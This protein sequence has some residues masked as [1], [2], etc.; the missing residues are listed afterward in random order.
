[1]GR[2]P[3]KRTL[4]DNLKVGC[5]SEFDGRTKFVRQMRERYG[6]LCEELGGYDNLKPSQRDL[7]EKYIWCL[8]MTRKFEALMIDCDD[9]AKHEKIH[10]RWVNATNVLQGVCKRLGLAQPI[11]VNSSANLGDYLDSK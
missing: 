2:K 7:L 5:L 3:K 10:R 6:E 1:M 11:K 4:P 8:T 9:D